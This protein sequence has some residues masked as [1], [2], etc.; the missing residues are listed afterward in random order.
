[1]STI[2]QRRRDAENALWDLSGSVQWAMR[3]GVFKGAPEHWVESIQGL[4][5]RV[6]AYLRPSDVQETEGASR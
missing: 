5:R 4:L 3:E 6:D 1:V 2:Q